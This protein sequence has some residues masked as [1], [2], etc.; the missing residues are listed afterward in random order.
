MR[1]PRRD[2]QINRNLYPR[3]NPHSQYRFE[4]LRVIH[5]EQ[6][7]LLHGLLVRSVCLQLGL[8]FSSLADNSSRMSV[9]QLS[10]DTKVRE[11]V[12]IYRRVERLHPIASEM[13]ESP[14][15][16]CMFWNTLIHDLGVIRRRSLSLADGEITAVQKAFEV[17]MK[18]EADENAAIE[19]YMDEIIGLKAIPERGRA[20]TLAQAIQTRD[21][22][23]NRMSSIHP[24]HG[25]P[26]RRLY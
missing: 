19:I 26:W 21:N 11:I 7:T 14:E 1:P 6:C 3:P 10:Q 5:L 23:L 16:K 25:A 8:E 12:K 18:R 15:L 20:K 4:L 24:H 2:Q 13:F 17:L 9:L 22:I